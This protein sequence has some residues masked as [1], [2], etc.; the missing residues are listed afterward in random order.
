M[1]SDEPRGLRHMRRAASTFESW[2]AS[3][4]RILADRLGGLTS[5]DLP[6]QPYRCWYDDHMTPTDAADAAMTDAACGELDEDD[7]S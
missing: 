1:M 5:D 7:Y 3:V 6:D 4:D 2:K